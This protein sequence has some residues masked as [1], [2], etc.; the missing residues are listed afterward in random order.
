M[1]STP[2]RGFTLIEVT[3]ATGILVVVAAGSAQ[4]FALAIHHN[5]QARRQLAMS[6]LAARKADDLTIAAAGGALRGSTGGALEQSLDGFSDTV[7]DGGAV[8]VRR[9]TVAAVPGR[10][11]L[12]AIAVRVLG[13]ASRAA[14]GPGSVQIATV[15][16]G[17]P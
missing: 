4:L 16:E 7:T 11:D 12:V 5:M 3:I 1:P 17:L 6:L 13:A 14:A 9:W 10:A 15:C 2:T 8:Y